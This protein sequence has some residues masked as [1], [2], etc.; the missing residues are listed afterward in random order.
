M[1]FRLTSFVGAKLWQNLGLITQFVKAGS[2][3]YPECPKP[4]QESKIQEPDRGS[5][6]ELSPQL[7]EV[8]DIRHLC[9][10]Y[11][12][13]CGPLLARRRHPPTARALP[14]D[15]LV[16]MASLTPQTPGGKRAGPAAATGKS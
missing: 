1:S 7:P 10:L 13:I 5:A 16:A 15:C 4:E 11:P 8:V 14:T 9:R 2:S 3:Q 6:R 12:G